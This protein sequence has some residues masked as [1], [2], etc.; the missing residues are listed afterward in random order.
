MFS[1][2]GAAKELEDTIADP[3]TA[4]TSQVERNERR[5][6]QER[7]L[8]DFRESLKDDAELSS[9]CDAMSADF[10]KPAEIE[11]LTGIP[12]KRVY[13]LKRKLK[14]RSTEFALNHPSAEALEIGRR[15]P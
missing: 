12:A 11:D 4:E 13:E 8:R 7:F 9:L 6:N 14:M 10:H 2:G 5:E 15:T 1:D 3:A